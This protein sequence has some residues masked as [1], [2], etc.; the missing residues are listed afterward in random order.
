MVLK[1]NVCV[2]HGIVSSLY[3][4]VSNAKSLDEI[5][6]RVN[7]EYYLRKDVDKEIRFLQGRIDFW[8]MK[9]EVINSKVKVK[10]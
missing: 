9:F 2:A 8:K 1:D 4:D 10:R 5:K 7:K 6:L 3:F